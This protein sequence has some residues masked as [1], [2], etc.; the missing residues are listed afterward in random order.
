MHFSAENAAFAAA[1]DKVRGAVRP[2]TIPILGHICVTAS[3]GNTVT[4]RAN[5][6][7]R[8]IEASFPAQVDEPGAA[9]LPGEVLLGV[10]K[11][12][13]KGGDC[14]LAMKGEVA[15][16]RASRSRYSLRTMPA[17]DFPASR[18]VADTAVRFEMD[19]EAFRA[20]LKAVAYATNPNDERRF[21]KGV[22]LIRNGDG[23][24]LDV[25]ATDGHRLALYQTPLP[26][27]AS[28]MPEVCIPAEG[29]KVLLDVFSDAETVALAATAGNVEVAAGN[30]RFA[31]ALIDTAYPDFWRL[32]PRDPP[33]VATVRPHA[34][35]EALERAAVV[36]STITEKL[37]P[38]VRLTRG[39]S[40]IMLDAG[41]AGAETGREL[42]EAETNGHDLNVG[43]THRYLADALR[44]WPE[45]AEV[46][47]LHSGNSAPVLFRSDSVSE[48]THLIMPTRI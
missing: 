26:N 44:A 19:G 25:V 38:A 10:V 24:T 39:E 11:R 15:E 6:L 3:D 45:S 42:V 2:S 8:E 14:E 5:N 17:A 27:G 36:F 4:V 7:E 22:A 47:L 30:V 37:V 33:T 41:R 20:A 21:C 32:I 28:E 34:L 29:V 1:L 18:T 40:T 9:A 31:T 46:R 13:P 16:I 35:A 43:L 23:R 48:Q 12:F